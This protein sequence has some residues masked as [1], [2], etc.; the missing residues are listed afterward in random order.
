MSEQVDRQNI[1][2]LLP[3]WVNGTLSPEERDMVEAALEQDPT[4]RQEAEMLALIRATVKEQPEMQSP[5]ELGLARLRRVIE[6]NPQTVL[7]GRSRARRYILSFSSGLAAAL[8]LLAVLGNFRASEDVYEL[9]SS[10]DD[11]ANIVVM[12]RPDVT[13]ASMSALLQMHDLVIVD[14]P[15]A[16]GLF[17][18]SP[19]DPDIDLEQLAG[20]LRSEIEVFESVDLP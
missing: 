13:Q 5:G 19:L 3:F 17:R 14:G 9:A 12:F 10:S 7:D 15:S 1:L 16:I 2:E 4:L 11:A 6:D 8:A 20:T 18:L